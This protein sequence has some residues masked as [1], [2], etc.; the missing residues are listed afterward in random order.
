MSRGMIAP[1]SILFVVV[2]VSAA[3]LNLT[4]TVTSDSITSSQTNV[5]VS[6]PATLTVVRVGADTGT[7]SASGSLANISGAT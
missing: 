6:G 1:L 5:S 7:F 2:G 3:I 4:F